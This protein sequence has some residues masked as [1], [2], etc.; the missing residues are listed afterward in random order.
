MLCLLIRIASFLMSTHNTHFQNKIR[1]LELSQ[2]NILI[3]CSYGKIL[4]NQEQVRNSCGKI[5]SHQCSSH[6]S[7]TVSIY[8]PYFMESRPKH[9]QVLLMLKVTRISDKNAHL[10]L[11]LIT[12][13]K[14]N[15]FGLILNSEL[16]N[17]I[18]P[19]I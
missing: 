10:K 16:N 9:S 11:P 17:L 5:F 18:W 6:G 1:A 7:S 8:I 3:F 13:F 12:H 19:N 4:G 2:I 14:I 15:L